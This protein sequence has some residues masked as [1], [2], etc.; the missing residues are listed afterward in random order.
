ML[1]LSSEIVKDRS[2]TLLGRSND[3]G[4]LFKTNTD[5]V[6]D[7]STKTLGEFFVD[8]LDRLGIICLQG[9]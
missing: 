3:F 8:S 6:L 9:N 5:K 4:N 1:Y 2:G 7:S